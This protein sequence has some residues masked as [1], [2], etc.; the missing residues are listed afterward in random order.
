MNIFPNGLIL[1]G[2]EYKCLEHLEADPEKWLIDAIAQ[3]AEARRTA[4]I[5][6]WRPILFADPL[7]SDFP[8]NN[9]ELAAFIISRD[10]YRSRAATD[11]AQDPPQLPARLNVEKFNSAARARSP[12]GAT[13]DATVTMFPRGLSLP[14]GDCDCILAYV[15]NLHDWVLGALLG[16]INRGRK[17]LISQYQPIISAD[18][19]VKTIRA[20]EDGFI[21]AIV[22]RSDYKNRAAR[23]SATTARVS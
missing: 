22:S 8:A 6:E 17:K 21:A 20:T 23:D 5:N 15:S 19:G 10:D 3:K 16:H 1:S 7:V 2:T 14:D 12:R 4:L 18:A 11:A 13:G 9:I